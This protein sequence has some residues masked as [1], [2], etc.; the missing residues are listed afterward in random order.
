MSVDSK[1]RFSSRVGDYVR[2][3]PRYPRDVVSMLSSEVGLTRD[4]VVADVG[5]G[6]GISAELFLE[7]GKV[8]WCVE[9]NREMRGAAEGL[10]SKYAGFR[11]VEGTAEETGLGSGS[12]DL[13]VCAQAFH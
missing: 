2:Y 11:S 1:A 5:A 12:I 8:V 4:W 6:T 13:I 9:P 7:N 3:R 10:L